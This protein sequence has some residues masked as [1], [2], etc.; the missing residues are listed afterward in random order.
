M[1]KGLYNFLNLNRAINAGQ[2]V[3]QAMLN[4]PATADM[5]QCQAGRPDQEL[6]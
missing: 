1:Y 4:S 6:A 5:K 2:R 3:F